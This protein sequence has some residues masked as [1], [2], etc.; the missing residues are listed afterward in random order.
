[1]NPRIEQLAGQALDQ[2]VPYTWTTLDRFELDRLQA[3]F[4]ELIIQ[5]CAAQANTKILNNLRPNE[6]HQL[7]YNE[8]LRDGVAGFKKYFGVKE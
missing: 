4:A 2:E 7:S 3:K 1:M 5:E 6:T 8:G